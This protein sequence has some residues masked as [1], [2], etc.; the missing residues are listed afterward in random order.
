MANPDLQEAEATYADI[1]ALPPALIGELI[2]GKLYTSPR[3]APPHTFVAS[4]LGYLA[5]LL[6]GIRASQRVG[7]N[8]ARSYPFRVGGRAGGPPGGPAAR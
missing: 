3:P 6:S 1:E 7:T 8:E 2:E 5:I 4:Q